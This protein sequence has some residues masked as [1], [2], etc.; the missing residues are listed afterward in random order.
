M[1][2]SDGRTLFRV[3]LVRRN[4]AGKVVLRKAVHTIAESKEQ[5]RRFVGFNN[6]G[7]EITR[8]KEI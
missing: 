6:R 1:P 5:A 7:Y 3:N 4:R 2:T 8:T